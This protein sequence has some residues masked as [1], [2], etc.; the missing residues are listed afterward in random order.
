M[1]AT[2][3]STAFTTTR[4]RCS[5]QNSA[6]MHS[7]SCGVH[8]GT[9]CCCG[10]PEQASYAAGLT[11]LMPATD[12]TPDQGTAYL[13]LYQ[14]LTGINL[15]DCPCRSILADIESQH[16]HHVISHVPH[17]HVQNKV[18]TCKY[19]YLRKDINVVLVIHVCLIQNL[20]ATGKD[21]RASAAP[22]VRP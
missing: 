6:A 3:L 17:L 10:F 12:S 16:V 14:L 9:M 20:D 4:A 1:Q 2:I 5:A 8:V 22:A 11:F 19:T 18:Y 15:S 21:S 7:A 13:L